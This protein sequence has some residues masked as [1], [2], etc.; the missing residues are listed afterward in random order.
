MAH[1]GKM[2]NSLTEK[3]FREINCLVTSN[4][5]KTSEP[6]ISRNSYQKCVR[7]K[8]RNFHI[9]NGL[10]TFPGLP[11]FFRDWIS[12]AFAPAVSE[13]FGRNYLLSSQMDFFLKSSFHENIYLDVT[14]ARMN[15]TGGFSQYSESQWTTASIQPSFQL[16]LHSKL[17]LS[18]PN[19]NENDF[20]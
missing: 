14:G 16:I 12:F 1:C 19:E 17:V 7:E 5:S 3:I 2:R 13:F 11:V 18:T 20:T 9:A 10:L 6:L 8:F 4:F 15:C